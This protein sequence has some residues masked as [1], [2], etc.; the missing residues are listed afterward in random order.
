[1][2][3]K[4]LVRDREDGQFIEDF[5]S[6]SLVYCVSSG[7]F[8]THDDHWPEYL[9]QLELIHPIGKKD[10]NGK[11]IYDWSLVRAYAPRK[12]ILIAKCQRDEKNCCY[13]FAMNNW[14]HL[15]MNITWDIEVVGHIKTDL[16][17]FIKA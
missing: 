13:V 7:N 17:T 2:R 10:I 4:F 9:K 8:S 3:D 16:D 15:S 11:M 14:V 6:S 12:K 5:G 1:M